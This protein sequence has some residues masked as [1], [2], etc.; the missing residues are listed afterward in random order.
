MALPGISYQEFLQIYRACR[1]LNLRA[2]R[3]ERL[4]A[5]LVRH[6]ESRSPC[7]AEP[8]NQLSYTSMQLLYTTLNQRRALNTKSRQQSS[9][10]QRPMPPPPP[11][12]P[13]SR[14]RDPGR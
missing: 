10:R 14:Q 11:S 3:S 8:L 2:Y 5:F 7:L 1:H 13:Q 4:R 12:Q 9:E 6:F